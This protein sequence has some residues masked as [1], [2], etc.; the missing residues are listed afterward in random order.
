[1]IPCSFSRRRRSGRSGSAPAARR[2]L[3]GHLERHFGQPSWR[4]CATRS[5]AST[6]RSVALAAHAGLPMLDAEHGRA[7]PACPG[8]DAPGRRRPGAVVWPTSTIV[9]SRAR[10]GVWPSGWPLRGRRLGDRG[11]QR[12]RDDGGPGR[13]AVIE[14]SIGKA[15]RIGELIGQAASVATR[16]GRRR[17]VRRRADRRGKVARRCGTGPA[18]SATIEG[19][20]S[21]RAA[22]CGWKSQRVLAVIE[23]PGHRHGA[24][25]IT[26]FDTYTGEALAPVSCATASEWWRWRCLARSVA[27]TGRAG[28][29]GPAAFGLDLPT[30]VVAS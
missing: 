10:G 26:V 4:C 7:F 12:V 20:G 15:L 19:I 25:I 18:H 28:P 22:R 23:T 21:D 29:A 30:A 14:G 16:R 24:G 3:R 13:D 17:R 9:W 8:V 6:A 2:T 1:V 5:A 11:E 27:H